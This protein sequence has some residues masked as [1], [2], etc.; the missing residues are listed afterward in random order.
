MVYRL[1]IGF[2]CAFGLPGYSSVENHFCQILLIFPFLHSFTDMG[3]YNKEASS[4]T[5]K[6]LLFQM[7]MKMK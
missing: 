4:L 6:D 2:I 7:F 1:Y 3:I 5:K